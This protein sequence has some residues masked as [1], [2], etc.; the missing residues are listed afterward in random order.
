MSHIK[1]KYNIKLIQKKGLIDKESKTYFQCEI[2]L[3]DY[4]TVRQVCAADGMF[5][6]G[7]LL[8]LPP[9]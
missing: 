9:E 3:K 5:G 7:Q 1:S 8:S 6:R 4:N 2:R